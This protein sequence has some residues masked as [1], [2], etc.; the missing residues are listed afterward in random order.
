MSEQ[1]GWDEWVETL[2]QLAKRVGISE[3]QI[4]HLVQTGQ[5]E[6]VMIGSRVHFRSGA[7]RRF[8]DSKT[9]KP[10]QD[11]TRVRACDGSRNATPTMSPGP[12]TAGA[13]SARL[14]RQTAIQL[15]HFS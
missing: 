8:L 12:S 1:R 6:H 3:R 13:A 14:A 11:E 15:Q 5:L 2:K 4:R 9:R 7:F 10:C